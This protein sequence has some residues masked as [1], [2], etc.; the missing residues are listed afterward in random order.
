MNPQSNGGDEAVILGMTASLLF[1]HRKESLSRWARL[2]R[3]TEER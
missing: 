2:S 1:G 3:V